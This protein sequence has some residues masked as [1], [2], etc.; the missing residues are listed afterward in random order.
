MKKQISEK[1]KQMNAQIIM[2]VVVGGAA[3][4]GFKFMHWLISFLV[5]LAQ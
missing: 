3:W 2:L 4:L 5:H 1:Q